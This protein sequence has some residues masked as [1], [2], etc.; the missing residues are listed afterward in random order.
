MDSKVASV[1]LAA[2]VAVPCLLLGASPAAASDDVDPG[3][4]IARYDLTVELDA[5]GV[6]QVDLVL[7]V[8]FGSR[9]NHG[10]YLT[11]VVKQPFEPEGLIDDDAAPQDRVYRMSDIRAVGPGDSPADVEVEEEGALLVLK[12]GDE[13]AELT[14]QHTY[15]VT[16]QVEGWVNSSELTGA[17]HDEL[18]LNVLGGWQ[19]PVDDVTVTIVGPAGVEDASCR[20]GERRAT[21]PCTSAVVEGGSAVYTEEHTDPGHHLT[22][23]ATFPAG[24]YGGVQ[25]ILQ[26]RWE[27]GRAFSLTPV[28]GGLAAVIAGLGTLLLARRARRTG[29]DAP[30]GGLTPGLVSTVGAPATGR[31]GGAA[32]VTLQYQP[33][34]GFRP[35]QLGTL[36]DERADAQD[37]TATLIDLAVRGHLRIEQTSAPDDGGEGGEW[38]LVRTR[39]AQAAGRAHDEVLLPYEELLLDEVFETGDAVDLLAL[40][41]TFAKSMAKVQDALYEDVTRRGWFRGNPK[42]T[43]TAWALGASAFLLLGVVVTVA[44]AIWTTWALV[45]VPLVL[46]GVGA[47]VLTGSAPARTAEGTDVLTQARGFREYL[48]TVAADQ[49]RFERDEDLFSRHL[50]YAVAFGLTE[51]WAGVFA[52]VATTREVAVP[53]WYVGAAYG[54]AF[55]ASSG[56]FGRDLTAFTQTTS[57]T[58][59]APT[60]S[61]SGSA[62]GSFA[63]GGVGGGG[64]GTW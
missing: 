46:L 52:D 60:P 19:I 42:A 24:T 59:A 26:D 36:L 50:P 9:P 22:V 31:G 37:V 28:T 1:V 33:P 3:D 12:I 2:L 23:L 11:Y 27:V 54:P 47:L 13:D 45:G 64:G 32:Q 16:L 6:A 63:G 4:R 34:A 48:A 17:D 29:R 53:A 8:D 7:D 10:P 35:G 25:P 43:R 58:L 56:T 20:A 55:W 41:A 51:R 62:G 39:A 44:L 21:T 57:Q 5:D 38:R 18:N 61:S 30:A 15:R 49:L 40:K 14:G